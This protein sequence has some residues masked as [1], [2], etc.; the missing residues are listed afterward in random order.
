MELE[1]IAALSFRER[2]GEA[3]VLRRKLS[4]LDFLAAV[5]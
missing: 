5:V 1:K 2:G 4:L 3:Q